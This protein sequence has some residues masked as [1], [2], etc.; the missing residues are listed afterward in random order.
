[1]REKIERHVSLLNGS[2]AKSTTLLQPD[3]LYNLD[4]LFDFCHRQ[5]WCHRQMFH[6]FK[7][8]HDLLKAFSILVVAPGII[9]GTVL[10]NAILVACLLVV[11]NVV[12]GWNDFKEFSF[13]VDKCRFAYSTYDKTLMELRTYV[14][15]L[16]IDEL[17]RFFI[18]MQPLDDTITDFA[19]PVTD[20]SVRDYE[21]Q[22]RY[23]HVNKTVDTTV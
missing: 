7:R 15:D 4:G 20:K 17:D 13:K 8:R 5:R 19:S 2:H 10:E 3:L 6:H 14:R 18:K 1:M 21:R 12:K 16:P 23:D 11:G 22:F 9:V